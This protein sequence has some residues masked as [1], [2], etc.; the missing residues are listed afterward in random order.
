MPKTLG[1]L[2]GFVVASLVTVAV[3][4]FIINRVGFLKN[5]TGGGA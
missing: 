2:V 3:G 5:L 4:L 1:G